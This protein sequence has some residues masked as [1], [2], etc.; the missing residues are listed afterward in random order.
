M[1]A[2]TVVYHWHSVD[3]SISTFGGLTPN[4]SCSA[5]KGSPCNSVCSR[6]FGSMN[7]ETGNCEC[8]APMMD[9][10]CVVIDEMEL[11]RNPFS[12]AGPDREAVPG[13][14]V[15]WTQKLDVQWSY[16]M[17]WCYPGDYPAAA[18]TLAEGS[19]Q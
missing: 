7:L 8:G 9:A 17:H 14:I 12:Y 4:I 2:A 6:C 1:T 16:E 3:Y 5:H 11:D 18:A 19:Q 13:R 15:V 10:E